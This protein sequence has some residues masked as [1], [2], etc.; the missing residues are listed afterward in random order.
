MV[1]V[2]FEIRKDIDCTL[3]KKVACRI[4]ENVQYRAQFHVFFPETEGNF[5]TFPTHVLQHITKDT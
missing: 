1:K 2:I 4:G 3:E 5:V